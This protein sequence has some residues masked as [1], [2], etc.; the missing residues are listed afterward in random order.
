MLAEG[1]GRRD[2]MTGR[3]V[4]ACPSGASGTLPC[5]G[6]EEMSEQIAEA[7]VTAMALGTATI[8]LAAGITRLCQTQP[9]QDEIG[10]AS[11]S[12]TVE[13]AVVGVRSGKGPN[14]D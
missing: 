14:A 3:T 8:N 2:R 5:P 11:C 10:R 4:R 9:G 12:D 7:L 6:W 13:G 1:S